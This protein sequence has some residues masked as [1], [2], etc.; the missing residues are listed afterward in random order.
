MRKIV[1]VLYVIGGA[2]LGVIFYLFLMGIEVAFFDFITDKV[3]GI[4][5]LIILVF[6]FF[7][8]RKKKKN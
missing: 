3:K 8:E 5:S 7:I 2:I 4:I 1:T 6:I